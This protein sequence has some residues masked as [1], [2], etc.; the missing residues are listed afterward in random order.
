M[1]PRKDASVGRYEELRT[2]TSESR[3]HIHSVLEIPVDEELL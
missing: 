3:R 1:T 2:D